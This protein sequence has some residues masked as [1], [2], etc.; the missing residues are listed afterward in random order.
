ME[1]SLDRKI[2]S[3]HADPSGSKEFIIADA[4][5]ADM[6]FGIGAPGLSPERHDQELKYKTL[7]EYRQQIREVI[8]QEI[9]DIVLMSAS[10]SEK[11]TIDE[12]LFDNSPIT[13]A[14]RAND[15]TDVHVPR[16]GVVHLSPAKP[17]RSASLDHIMCGHLDCKPE[18]RAYGADLGLYSVTFNNNL[19][20]D[21][22]TLERYKEFREEAERKK[23]RH[24]LE[25]F[26]PN[27]SNAV[28][29]DMAPGFIN[30]LIA[31]TLAGVASAGRPT[32]LKMVYHGPR[33]MQELVAY[34]PHLIVGI[35]GGSAGTT[36]DAFQLIYDARK[37]GARVALFGRKINQAEHQLAFIQFLRFLVEDKI[38][39]IEAVKAY[40]GVLQEL[41]IKP[42]RSLDVDLTYQTA[43]MSYGGEDGKTFSFPTQQK[44]GKPTQEKSAKNV[45]E[46]PDFASMSSEE[47]LA[48]H[49]NRLNRTFGE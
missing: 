16:G 20:E 45:T 35:L 33:A 10:T 7:A 37:Y 2:R 22:A 40:H 49:R 21:L 46:A 26:D 17:F 14:A 18:E 12:R 23:F 30:D 28:S 24:F 19:E 44:N 31:R 9:V 13:P 3:I 47:R 41:D 29:A 43:V 38:Q 6:A 42:T 11:L 32:F 8:Q 25:I 1:K 4:K 39:P 15:T 34:D 36:L 48:Y 27:I 5:D